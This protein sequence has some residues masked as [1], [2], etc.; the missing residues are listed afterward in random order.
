MT[1]TLQYFLSCRDRA[2]V[3]AIGKSHDLGDGPRRNNAFLSGASRKTDAKSRRSP[4]LP[5][6]NWKQ[7]VLSMLLFN[8]IM[9]VV[10]YMICRFS[11]GFR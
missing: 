3:V 9:F 8:A 4:C 10:V 1:I 11:N 5:A 7:Y 6:T 2:S